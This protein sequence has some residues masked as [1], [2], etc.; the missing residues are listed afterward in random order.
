MSTHNICKCAKKKKKRK[1]KT[2]KHQSF[3][4]TK[5][6]Y[7]ELCDAQTFSRRAENDQISQLCCAGSSGHSRLGEYTT[8]DFA[9]RASCNMYMYIVFL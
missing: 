8:M 3:S 7:L 6:S 9:W 2:N 1:K 4:V 5:V